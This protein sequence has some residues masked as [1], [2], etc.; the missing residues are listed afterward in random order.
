MIYESDSAQCT[1]GGKEG[2][3]KKSF[4]ESVSDDDNEKPL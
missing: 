4:V 2:R 1:A 3:E